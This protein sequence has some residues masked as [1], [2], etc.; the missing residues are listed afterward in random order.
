ML[1]YNNI[2][3]S[4]HAPAVFQR[5]VMQQKTCHRMVLTSIGTRLSGRTLQQKYIDHKKRVLLHRWVS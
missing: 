5:I 1:I 4:V 3:F 2:L